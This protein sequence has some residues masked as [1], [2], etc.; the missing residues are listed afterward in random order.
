MRGLKLILLISLLL[1]TRQDI[2]AQV[3]QTNGVEF[4]F[5]FPEVLDKTNASF[6]VH[7][8][9]NDSTSGTVSI[10]GTGY[11]QA[12]N[13]I[14]NV[15]TK[16]VIPSSDANIVNSDTV[17]PRGI[18]LVTADTVTCY[19]HTYHQFRSDVSVLLPTQSFGSDYWVLSYPNTAAANEQS[20]FIIVA[21]SL[22][23]IIITSTVNTEGGHTAMFPWLVTLDSGDVYMVQAASGAGNDVTGTRVRAANGQDKFAVFGGHVWTNIECAANK[24]PLYQQLYPIPTWGTDYVLIPTKG[25]NYNHYRV[26][27]GYSG[28]VISVNGTTI[29]T[30]NEGQYFTDTTSKPILI[31]A[32]NPVSVMQYMVSGACT[33]NSPYTGGSNGGDPSMCALTANSQ[34]YTDSAT[35]FVTYDFDM[36][37]AFIIVVTRTVD[38]A[39]CTLNGSTLTNWSILSP[40]PTYSYL[41][42]PANPGSYTLLSSGLGMAAYTYAFQWAES[43]M[44]SLGINK[45]S[46]VPL[47]VSMR[48]FLAEVDDEE[49]RT[50][51][52]TEQE[53]DNDRFEILRSRNG[54]DFMEIGEVAGKGNSNSIQNYEF[55]DTDPLPGRS[56]Y[57]MRQVDLNGTESY[58]RV[59]PILLPVEKLT[60]NKLHPNPATNRITVTLE[61][62]FS[63]TAIVQ[64]RD[65]MGRLWS[66]F[67]HALEDGRNQIKLSIEELPIGVYSLSTTMAGS[68]SSIAKFVKQ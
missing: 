40:D 3:L 64:V 62:P 52:S 60:I 2:N 63:G 67:P 68:G 26:M 44:Y 9:S 39:T 6:S 23:N 33:P 27:S 42:I 20:E 1:V 34:M 36:D 46:N 14:P 13:V 18:H 53:S 17:L 28:T 10:P 12:F 48:S 4:W 57:K 59:V 5:A 37:T 54:F 43:Y 38:T 32:T 51:W 55:F 35:F 31:S 22:V 65:I 11:S 56:Y 24:D 49:V 21:P 19:A 50:F 30:F 61:T 16:I 25:Q 45:Q 29:G 47:P 41:I 15:V 66:E 7:V 58:S 8:S